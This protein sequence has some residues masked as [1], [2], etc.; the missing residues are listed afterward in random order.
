MRREIIGGIGGIACIWLMTSISMPL[1]KVLGT[2]AETM[3]VMTLRG[4]LM[5]AVY[6]LWIA[7]RRK[8]HNRLDPK[9]LIVGLAFAF[10]NL[11]IYKGVACWGVG[12]V[13]TVNTAAPV[14]NIVAARLRGK[15]I[16]L[17]VH[18]FSL[19]L[20]AG[21]ALAV[22]VGEDGTFNLA[23]LLWSLMGAIMYGVFYEVLALEPENSIEEQVL[24]Q[25]LLV[26]A[27]GYSAASPRNDWIALFQNGSF[28]ATLLVFS[29]TG[30][31]LLFIGNVI[32]F[33]S[34]PTE[35]ASVLSQFRTPLTVVASWFLVREA[36]TA[37]EL[38]GVM[39]ATVGAAGL[40]FWI[41]RV[42]KEEE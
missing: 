29:L 16:P 15:A 7:F 37:V 33:A 38:T 42:K 22:K 8:R 39:M 9:T 25:S 28:M 32:A 2:E 19:L 18:L 31:V 17:R 26:G 1:L 4:F 12:P 5:A 20:F 3:Q 27:V 21:V 40:L 11:G 41:T 10:A 24:W 6:A 23:G 14:V 36:F 30:G 34:L 35:I 13:V